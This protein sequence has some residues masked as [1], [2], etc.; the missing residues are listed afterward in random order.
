MYDFPRGGG[1]VQPMT[2]WI[3]SFAPHPPLPDLVGLPPPS[4]PE[5]AVKRL[6]PRRVWTKAASLRV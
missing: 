5:I 1:T 4:G 2:L 3:L 6:A